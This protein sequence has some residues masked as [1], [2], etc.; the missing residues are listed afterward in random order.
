MRRRRRKGMTPFAAG[1]LVIA[2]VA[3]VTFLVFGNDIP[4]TRPFQVK[5]VLANAQ[6]IR[7]RSPVRIAGV[8]V[9]EVQKVQ[10]VGDATTTVLTVNV[11]DRGLPLYKDAEVKV[12]PRIFLEG[13]FFLDVQPGTPGA[14]KIADGGTIP[15]SQTTAPV[16]LD[17]VLTSLQHNTRRDLQKL[18]QGY[19]DALDAPPKP[20]EDATQVPSVRGLTA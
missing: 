8:T 11:S 1:A 6:G 14:G 18:V 7:T 13:N 15:V 9:G 3:V 5:V 20:G 12:R 19:G 10:N 2:I 4:F 17:Q 16:Q